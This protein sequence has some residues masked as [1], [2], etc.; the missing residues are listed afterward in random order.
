M[1][2]TLTLISVIFSIHRTIIN[3]KRLVRLLIL[4]LWMILPPAR[5]TCMNKNCDEGCPETPVNRWI[6]DEFKE[7]RKESNASITS[8]FAY[9]F[10]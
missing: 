2:L 9:F 4:I 5:P 8:G 1:Y 7:Q 10:W 3:N 6:Q